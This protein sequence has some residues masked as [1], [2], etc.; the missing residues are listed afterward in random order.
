MLS[1]LKMNWIWLGSIIIRCWEGRKIIPMM[2][3][4]AK[5]DRERERPGGHMRAETKTTFLANHSHQSTSLLALYLPFSSLLCSQSEGVGVH[6]IHSAFHE[7]SRCLANRSPLRETC[8]MVA[9]T[10]QNKSC[11]AG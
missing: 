5:L 1:T 11:E 9:A 10:N 2:L 8:L 4:T 7:F 6:Y 3:H